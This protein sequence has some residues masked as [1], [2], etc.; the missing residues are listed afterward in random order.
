MKRGSIGMVCVVYRTKNLLHTFPRFIRGFSA[1]RVGRSLFLT[2]L[3]PQSSLQL[4][5]EWIIQLRKVQFREIIMTHPMLLLNAGAL[6]EDASKISDLI[7]IKAK[8]SG[9]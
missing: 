2:R 5:L 7:Y 8:I 3:V 9:A 1:F 6:L 4:S